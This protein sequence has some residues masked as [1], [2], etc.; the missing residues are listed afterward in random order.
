MYVLGCVPVTVTG[1]WVITMYRWYIGKRAKTIRQC[2]NVLINAPFLILCNHIFQVKPVVF[3]YSLY[4]HPI[5]V[6]IF[7]VTWFCNPL[8]WANHQP[9]GLGFLTDHRRLNVGITRA[10]SFLAPWIG[11]KTSPRVDPNSRNACCRYIPSLKLTASLHL[12][13]DGWKMHSLL[14]RLIFRGFCC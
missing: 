8:G 5:G 6:M 13:M 1:R 4:F 10:K 7:P 9:P 11:G 3:Q 2:Q 14:G 12:K